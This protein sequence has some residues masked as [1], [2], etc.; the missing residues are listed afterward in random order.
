MRFFILAFLLGSTTFSCT[1]ALAKSKKAEA[2]T[3]NKAW[4]GRELQR[5]RLPPSFIKK[6]M[7]TYEPESFKT[8]LTLN[9]LGFLKPGQHMNHVN[10]KSTKEAGS[11][12]ESNRLAFADAENKYQVPGEVI[13]SLMWI[14]TRH[15]QDMGDFHTVSVYLDLLQSDLKKNRTVLT[16]MAMER[17]KEFKK[18]TTAELRK[19][20]SERTKARREWAKEQLGALA[21]AAKKKHLDIGT[22]RGSYAGAFGMPQF[23]PSSYRDYA[24][25]NKVGVAPDL[26]T[27]EDAILSVANYLSKFGWMNENPEAMVTALMKYNNSRDYADAILEI[28]K[29]VKPPVPASMTAPTSS[30]PAQTAA[31]ASPATGPLSAE[32]ETPPQSLKER[33]A[34]SG[35]KKL[36]AEP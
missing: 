34:S 4:V 2:L 13:S 6:A 27:K 5:L 16:K 22:L 8:V 21:V 3:A 31:T 24:V 33:T 18:Y 12:V 23:I 17:N 20:M 36:N 15:G 1:M 10:A 9:L 35:E 11:F 29:L 14:E 28:A 19:K 7:S 25:T 32:P 30:S 26:T